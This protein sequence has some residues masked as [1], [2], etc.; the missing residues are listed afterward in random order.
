MSVM[1]SNN[2][3]KEVARYMIRC[4]F[5]IYSIMELEFMNY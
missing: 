2:V 1:L 3:I 4:I 5:F